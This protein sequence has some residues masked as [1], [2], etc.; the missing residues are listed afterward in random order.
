MDDL[1]QPAF[2]F[3]STVS[4]IADTRKNRTTTWRLGETID[5]A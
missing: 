1:N 4:V 3:F 5:D 2:P